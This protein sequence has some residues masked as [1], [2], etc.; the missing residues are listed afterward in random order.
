MH[1]HG[2]YSG[3]RPQPLLDQHNQHLDVANG[4]EDEEKAGG[5]TQMEREIN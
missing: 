5:E 1:E 4:G 2:V 3:G